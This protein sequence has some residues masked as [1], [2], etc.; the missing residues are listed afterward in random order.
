MLS[1]SEQEEIAKNK[2]PGEPLTWDDL[3]KMKY[4]WRVASEILRIHPPINFTF[5]KAIQDIEYGGYII[6]KGWQVSNKIEF[7]IR[8]KLL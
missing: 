1:Y 4:T 3:N 2:A 5:R 6:P 8:T 7:T